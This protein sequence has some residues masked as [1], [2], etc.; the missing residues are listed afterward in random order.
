MICSTGIDFNPPTQN[1]T[2]KAGHFLLHILSCQR[3][4]KPLMKL[5]KALQIQIHLQI[6]DTKQFVKYWQ[7]LL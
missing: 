3:Y 4:K 1:T 5:E 2:R 7:L 6:M